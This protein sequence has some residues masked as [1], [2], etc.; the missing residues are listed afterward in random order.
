MSW[1]GVLLFHNNLNLLFLLLLVGWGPDFQG[2]G[3]ISF[4][5]DRYN[6]YNGFA[7]FQNSPKL[8]I[9]HLFIYFSQETEILFFFLSVFSCF[10]VVS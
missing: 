6:L 1:A 8:E 7:S 9:F 5:G 10:F 2:R 3:R 4:L